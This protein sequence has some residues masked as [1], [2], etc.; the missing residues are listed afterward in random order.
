MVVMAYFATFRVMTMKSSECVLAIFSVFLTVT[1]ANQARADECDPTKILMA[2]SVNKS[3]DIKER[4]DQSTS[5]DTSDK[6]KEGSSG[7][8]YGISGGQNLEFEKVLKERFQLHFEGDYRYAASY[9]QLS[10]RAKDAYVAC[11]ESKN[12]HVFVYPADDVMSAE[13]TYVKVRLETYIQSQGY[14]VAVTVDGAKLSY[15]QILVMSEV[16]RQ[17]LELAI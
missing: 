16:R 1:F 7:N 4:L 6:T 13:N 5:R 3:I 9:L 12:Q 10:Q 15:R 17:R 8:Y 14:P 11:L 2:D